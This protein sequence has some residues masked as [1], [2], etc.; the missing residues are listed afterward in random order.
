MEPNADRARYARMLLQAS[1]A[2][3]GLPAAYEGR[4]M[5]DVKRMVGA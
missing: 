3:T 5:A 1:C 2:P 4:G